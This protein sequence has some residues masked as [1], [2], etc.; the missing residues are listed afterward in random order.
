MKT[1]PLIALFPFFFVIGCTADRTNTR[2]LKEVV[3]LDFVESEIVHTKD[4]SAVVELAA[5]AAKLLFKL[6]VRELA[7]YVGKVSESYKD[8]YSDSTAIKLST[9]ATNGSEDLQWGLPMT[10]IEKGGAFVFYRAVTPD[11]ENESLTKGLT[12]LTENAAK[13]YAKKFADELIKPEIGLEVKADKIAKSLK[14]VVD[15]KRILTFLAVI[16]LLPV[17]NTGTTPTYELRLIGYQYD[18]V[19]VKNLSH[20]VWFTDWHKSES[21][22][23]ISVEGPHSDPRLNNGKY[24]ASFTCPLFW[25]RRS[26]NKRLFRFVDH[27]RQ[28]GSY[29]SPLFVT[30]YHTNRLNV[31]V[32]VNE[33]NDLYD[34]LQNLKEQLEDVDVPDFEDEFEDLLE[35]KE[36]ELPPQKVEVPDEKN[37]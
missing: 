19:K 35:D 4:E 13:A 5:E 23:T 24:S 15:E 7:R 36:K 9:K 2:E 27:L 18:A 12:P 28:P 33:T 37:P 34:D 11:P 20:R 25:S 22:L 29:S 31:T 26:K 8:N 16:A 32:T 30:P 3:K 21:T 1:L 6:G 10:K 14:R 17:E